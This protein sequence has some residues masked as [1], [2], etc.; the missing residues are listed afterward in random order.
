VIV[1]LR[2]GTRAQRSSY[3]VPQQRHHRHGHDPQVEPCALD[4]ELDERSEEDSQ[5]HDPF[6]RQAPRRSNLSERSIRPLTTGARRLLDGQGG[7]RAFN[8]DCAR[9]LEPTR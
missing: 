2:V 8:A 7:L 6:H 9:S 3:E 5:R 4:R 1:L